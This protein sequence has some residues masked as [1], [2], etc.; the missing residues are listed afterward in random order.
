MQDNTDCLFGSNLTISPTR[1]LFRIFTK[2][3]RPS[4]AHVT[5]KRTF[6]RAERMRR[7]SMLVFIF[8]WHFLVYCPVA[9]SLWAPDGFL[10]SAGALDFAGGTV[11]HVCSGFS[12]PYQIS[13]HSESSSLSLPARQRH[14]WEGRERKRDSERREKRY[15]EKER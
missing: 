14:S 3:S 13:Y 2:A 6:T 12:G 1:A 5:K 11:V 4:E 7:S 9:H 8:F 15:K 10:A